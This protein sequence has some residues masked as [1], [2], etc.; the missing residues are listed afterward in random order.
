M[1]RKKCLLSYVFLGL[2]NFSFN[3]SNDKIYCTINWRGRDCKRDW[4]IMNNISAFSNKSQTNQ[5]Q[6]L[7]KVASPSQDFNPVLDNTEQQCYKLFSQA[8]I[9]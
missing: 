5:V 3:G 7:L 9:C 1:V 4:P 2:C 8:C 6:P